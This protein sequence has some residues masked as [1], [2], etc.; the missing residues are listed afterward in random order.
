M[1]IPIGSKPLVCQVST[2]LQIL[3]SCSA[4]LVHTTSSISRILPGSFLPG[5]DSIPSQVQ[6]LNLPTLLHVIPSAML[7][8]A[9]LV[10]RGNVG[11]YEQVFQLDLPRQDVDIF[12]QIFPFALEAALQVCGLCFLA[13]EASLQLLQLLPLLFHFFL[14]VGKERMDRQMS[15][16]LEE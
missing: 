16:G 8:D 4:G 15:T 11:R 1:V 12:Q 10:M 6:V 9:L 14:M 2:R 13:L 3:I 7:H 5:S